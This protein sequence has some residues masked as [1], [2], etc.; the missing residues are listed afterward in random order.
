MQRS[1]MLFSF[2][3]AVGL[4]GL[5][6]GCGGGGSSSPATGSTSGSAAASGT[7]T[8]F[9]SVFVNGKRF[10]ANDVEVRHDGITERCTVNPTTTCGLKQGMTVTVTG[11]FDGNKWVAGTLVQKDAVE[12]LVQSIAADGSSLVV[13][14]R[15]VLVDR[16]TLIDNNISGQNILSLLVGKDSVEVNGYIRPTGE[17]QATFIEKKAVG[18][19][20]PEVR[21]FAKNHDAGTKTFQIGGLNVVYDNNTITIDMP[22]PTGNAWN[23]LFV[24]VKGTNFDSAT[25]TLIATKI[26]PENQVVQQADEFEVEG[27]VTQV[28][29]P[30]NFFIGTTHVQTTPSTE[31]RGGTIDEIVEGVKLSVDGELANGILTATHVATNAAPVITSTPTLVGTQGVAYS[32][33]VDATDANGDTL[34][35]SL[36]EPA[37]FGMTIDPATGVISWT[38][39]AQVGDNPVT[40]Q[41]SDGS[42]VASQ[43]FTVKVAAVV[44]P[45]APVFITPTVL[46]PAFVQTSYTTTVIATDANGDTLTYSLMDSLVNSQV[47]P[48]PFGMTIDPAS[49]LITWTPPAQAGDYPV[50]VQVSDGSLVAS[51][52]FT[53]N[54][55]AA[56]AACGV[57][58]GF[59]DL[60]RGGF[61][62]TQPG[63][64][65]NEGPNAFSTLSGS[66]IIVRRDLEVEIH[67]GSPRFI[68]P[69]LTFLGVTL[70]NRGTSDTTFAI[71]GYTGSHG[72]TAFYYTVTIKVGG[73]SVTVLNSIPDNSNRPMNVPVERLEVNGVSLSP[74]DFGVSSL[75]VGTAGG[76]PPCP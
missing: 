15:T 14:G 74:S 10:E 71:A 23:G 72:V 3:G 73:P 51:Q 12:G 11:S 58:F 48:P 6:G 31:F 34:T 46:P 59:D 76:A 52:T 30:G 19:V 43:T 5:L 18:T 13:M 66:A 32:Y 65:T 67:N 54:V 68:Q 21:G 63:I 56:T 69:E 2:L 64:W 45:A 40:V 55:N 50:T 16:G 57:T 36:V 8:G 60:T 20:T 24:E 4:V 17:I 38:P 33:D 53:I 49:G 41:V 35:Y 28:V 47:K 37:P 62:V 75:A 22:N 44:A 61:N 70:I 27:F 26:E 7:V 39:A 1:S 42:L 29:G 25:T 9:G